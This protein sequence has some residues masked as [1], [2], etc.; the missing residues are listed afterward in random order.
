MV[1]DKRCHCDGIAKAARRRVAAARQRSSGCAP[2]APAAGRQQV[3]PASPARPASQAAAPRS[4]LTRLD[5]RPSPQVPTA[6]AKR[7]RAGGGQENA[8]RGWRAAMEDDGPLLP[9]QLTAGWLSPLE[10]GDEGPPVT[11]AEELPELGAG[12]ACAPAAAEEQQQQQRQKAKRG[13][14]AGG[15]G[16]S[17]AARGGGW[18]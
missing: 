11:A 14:R 15:S 4:P 5:Q 12:S 9:M 18:S 7:P 17:Q 2:A 16:R 13:K 3:A 10:G 8:G 6:G 1:S